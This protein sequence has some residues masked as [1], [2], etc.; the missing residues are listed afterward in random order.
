MIIL[1]NTEGTKQSQGNTT[2]LGR[3]IWDYPMQNLIKSLML[4]Q[5]KP[6]NDK[7]AFIPR[8]RRLKMCKKSLGASLVKIILILSL[9]IKLQVNII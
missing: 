4:F 7:N 3:Q 5:L 6:Y 9:T 8:G 1:T 2:F